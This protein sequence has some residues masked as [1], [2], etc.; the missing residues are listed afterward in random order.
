MIIASTEVEAQRF[1]FEAFTRHPFFTEV[2]R[3]I[4]DRVIG[5]GRERIVD[6]GCGPGAVTQLIVDRV[7]PETRVIGI[8]PSESA[9]ARARAAIK[10]KAAE[11]IQ[12][13]AEWVSRL[14]SSVDAVVFLN[15]IHLVPDKAQVMAEIRK[16]LN[17][18]GVFAFNTTF[19]NGAY[20][21][22]TTG[23]WRRWIVRA[24][25]VLRERG[26]D[27]RRDAKAEVA[28]RFLSASE[29]ANLCV[30]A[31]FEQPKVDLVRIEMTPESLEDIGHYSLFIEGALP[32]VPLEAGAE[33]L[34]EGLRRA[35]ED[36]GFTNVPRNWLECVATAV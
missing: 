32:G 22:G 4:V 18:G 11:F 34:K 28:R 10:S 26:L 21:E 23:F 8:D 3:W 15:A 7:D 25:Q 33:A 17:A 27:V 36:T 1:S 12:G 20:V 5:P 19:F 35:Q 14:V 24:V 2:N 16:S 29:Y 30:Q 9:L 13:S 6:L 31:G